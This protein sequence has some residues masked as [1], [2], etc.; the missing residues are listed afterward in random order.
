MQ[1]ESEKKNVIS[2]QKFH[3]SSISSFGI[4]QSLKRRKYIFTKVAKFELPHPRQAF[5]GIFLIIYTLTFGIFFMYFLISWNA[6]KIKLSS[7]LQLKFHI[8]WKVS[9]SVISISSV[10]DIL[11]KIVFMLWKVFSLSI[12]LFQREYPLGGGIIFSFCSTPPLISGGWEGF[13]SL[14]WGLK[15]SKLRFTFPYERLEI[16]FIF[17]KVTR[18]LHK[19]LI[20]SHFP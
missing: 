9:F 8:I 11:L 19:H 2:F 14:R 3:D 4:P 17:Y 6:L 12:S 7:I 10:R 13:W 20:P 1:L 15:T 16:L 18:I 5:S